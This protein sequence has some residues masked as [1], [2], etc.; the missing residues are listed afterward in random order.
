[1]KSLSRFVAVCG[2]VAGTFWG[3]LPGH[4]MAAFALPAQEVMQKLD[5]PVF[6]VTDGQGSLLLRSINVPGKETKASVAPIFINK[7]DADDFVQKL[8]DQLKSSV[9]VT[10]VSLG[11]VYQISQ[12]DK[13]R[14]ENLQFA[15]IPTEQQVNLAEDIQKQNG[16]TGEFNGVPLFL[17]RGGADNGYLV[18]QQGDQEVIPMFFSKQDLLNMVENFKKQQPELS[19]SIKVEVVNLEGVMTALEKDND[20][21]LKKIVLIPPRESIEFVQKS[22]GGK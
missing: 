1:M 17:A 13:S 5:V 11:K 14:Q 4:N 12:L 20:P 21:F 19:G 2:V 3:N 18:I 7:K 10:I 15:F 6:A 22:G 9:K 8:D 16:K